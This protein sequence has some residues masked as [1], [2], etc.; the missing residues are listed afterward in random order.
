MKKIA[1]ELISIGDEILIGQTVN[2]N[3]TF[4]SRQITELGGSVRWITAVGDDARDIRDAIETAFARSDITIATG[5]LGPTH[6]DITK[7][8]VAQYFHSELVLNEEALKNIDQIFQRM[9]RKVDRLNRDQALIPECATVLPNPVGTAPG[10]LFTK[11]SR[12]LIIL[13]G[14]PFEMEAIFKESM[15]PIFRKA[16]SRIHI[17]YKTI[18]T[19]GL[20]ES[21]LFSMVESVLAEI[22]PDIHV[23]FLPT[24]TGVNLR[25]GTQA[26]TEKACIRRLEHAAK[27]LAE[28]IGT[29]VYSTDGRDIEEIVAERLLASKQTVATVEF[30]TK[31]LFASVFMGVPVGQ[32]CFKGSKVLNAEKLSDI[33]MLGRDEFSIEMARNIK[34]ELHSD[35]GISIVD[36][37]SGLPESKPTDLDTIYF[38]LV[39]N[40]S[41][42]AET[43]RYR[44][45]RPDSER[46]AVQ[47]AFDMLRRHLS[48][49]KV[50]P[51]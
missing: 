40:H 4:L 1:F 24:F 11:N 15:V 21:R 22:E 28:K 37:A 20:F 19:T 29:Y 39:D 36:P 30:F 47:Y 6:D 51:Q 46:R 5:G 50:I 16:L 26:S 49:M 34:E 13:P 14:V 10:L 48:G 41:A 43:W 31:G 33:G 42:K 12:Q 32:K 25:L 45:E 7:K 8:T 27:L 3:A 17:K 23:A 18:K 38:G 9:G 44:R 35:I 2:T